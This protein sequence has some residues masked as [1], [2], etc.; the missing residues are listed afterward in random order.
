[1][2]IQH[3]PI[4]I[5]PN[6]AESVRDQYYNKTFPEGALKLSKPLKHCS[7]AGMSMDIGQANYSRRGCKSKP[8]VNAQ[9]LEAPRITIHLSV[10]PPGDYVWDAHGSM[11][12]L[13]NNESCCTALRSSCWELLRKCGARRRQWALGGVQYT[14]L[15]FTLNSSIMATCS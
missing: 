7:V 13:C 12:W 15:F 5:W 14:S 2:N 11:T 6:I 1:M 10:N 3:S 8:E 4:T 9:N